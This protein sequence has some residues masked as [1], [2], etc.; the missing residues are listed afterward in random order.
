M[1]FGY[2]YTFIYQ[3]QNTTIL[4]PIEYNY[5][6]I[7]SNHNNKKRTFWDIYTKQNKQVSKIAA[8]ANHAFIT[9]NVTTIMTWR[10][11]AS[12]HKWTNHLSIFT[13]NCCAILPWLSKFFL[14][15]TTDAVHSC[16]WQN[17]H[18]SWITSSRRRTPHGSHHHV[19]VLIM[20]HIITSTYSSWITSSRRRTHHGSHHHVDV[21][22]MD[23]IITSTYLSWITS[24]KW[25]LFVH[26]TAHTCG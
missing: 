14:A 7:K 8:W 2:F 10:Y 18:A 21:L 5:L 9:L 3:H 16:R 22:I 25:H 11:P 1:H 19:D 4:S 20:D 23:H 13:T 17:I 12:T 6:H 15:S 24:F 26:V